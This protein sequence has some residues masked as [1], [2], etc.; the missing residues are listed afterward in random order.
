MLCRYYARSCTISCLLL[1]I[2]I[3]GEMKAVIGKWVGSAAVMVGRRSSSSSSSSSSLSSSASITKKVQPHAFQSFDLIFLGTGGSNPSRGRGMPSTLLDLGGELWMFD[4]G[5]GTVRQSVFVRTCM[6][7]SRVF[8]THMHA[9]HIFGLP[10][11]IVHTGM[12]TE[13]VDQLPP[14]SIYGPYG[15][16]WSARA[17]SSHRH[18]CGFGRD[19]THKNF[20]AK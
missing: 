6:D 3:D 1:L 20:L 13:G 17:L 19:T 15:K 9:D 18:P 4:V 10:G 5:E 16:S 2:A 14:L 7:T 12:K 11:L 8:I